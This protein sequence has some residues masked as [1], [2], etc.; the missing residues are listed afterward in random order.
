MNN[1]EAYHKILEIYNEV[2]TTP[3]GVNKY[4]IYK[5][6][7]KKVEEIAKEFMCYGMISCVGVQE[8]VG[9]FLSL[10][11]TM[12]E[13]RDKYISERYNEL[14]IGTVV[15]LPFGQII[16]VENENSFHCCNGCYLIGNCKRGSSNTEF[17]ACRKDYRTDMKNVIFKLKED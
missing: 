15:N 6:A 14:P 11:K 13:D 10:E 4:E 17:G 9:M 3:D 2:R 5:E 8:A 7:Y 12:K 1:I 16:V